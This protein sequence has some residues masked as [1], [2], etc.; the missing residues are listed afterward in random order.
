MG[1]KD[2]GQR[3]VL[4][5]KK[6][7]YN[8]CMRHFRQPDYKKQRKMNFSIGHIFI[9]ASGHVVGRKQ[10]MQYT[11]Q[12]SI[13]RHTWQQGGSSRGDRAESNYI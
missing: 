5:V 7:H 9:R 2:S 1:E 13:R 10:T 11:I 4:L 12:G 8:A 6:W 3:L